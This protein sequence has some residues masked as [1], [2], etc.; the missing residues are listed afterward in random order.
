[1]ARINVDTE[2]MRECGSN[3]VTYANEYLNAVNEL[4]TR[5][6]KVKTANEWNGSSAD[7]FISNVMSDKKVYFDVGNQLKL[8]GK[9]L[10]NS[11]YRINRVI[12]KN[13]I[14]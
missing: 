2:L 12:S 8:M 6:S 13:N 9:A 10:T 11:S 7:A 1:M 14:G 5:L 3:I 4:C